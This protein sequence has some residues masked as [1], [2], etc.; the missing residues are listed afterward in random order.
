MI[1]PLFADDFRAQLI[2]PTCS[3][4]GSVAL[5]S[6]CGVSDAER[7]GNRNAR[8]HCSML[9]GN[10]EPLVLT[11][12]RKAWRLSGTSCSRAIQAVTSWTYRDCRSEAEEAH[13]GSIRSGTYIG[14]GEA[15]KVHKGT[16][17]GGA[18]G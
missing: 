18:A 8:L 3:E 9:P 6:D 11:G 10:S 14:A 5:Q 17:T 15:A 12:Q 1:S 7:D 4:Q 16:A 2:C 13:S